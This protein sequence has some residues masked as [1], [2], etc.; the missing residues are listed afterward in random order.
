[1][2]QTFRPL[3]RHWIFRLGVPLALVAWAGYLAMDRLFDVAAI[4][5]MYAA[6]I[7]FANRP[8]IWQRDLRLDDQGL[9]ARLGRETVRVLWSDVIAAWQVKH[10]R[11]SFLNLSSEEVTVGIPLEF[12]GSRAIWEAVQRRVP[13][14][15][16]EAGAYRRSPEYKTHLARAQSLLKDVRE[17]LRADY[18]LSGKIALLAIGGF[19][20]ITVPL[21]SEGRLEN[22]AEV[23]F[24]LGPVLLI[25]V[26]LAALSFFYRV[27][28]TSE[29]VT[30]F[31][32]W[33]RQV[34]RWDEVEY[35]EHIY[36]WGRFV[37]VGRDRRLA[38]IGP[39]YL[40]GKDRVEMFEMLHAQIELRPIELRHRE[41]ALFTGSHNVAVGRS[42]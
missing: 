28:M 9:S 4:L 30:V 10:G 14:E 31:D 39:P 42:A 26:K 32:L 34:M 16:L 29:A 33:K 2:S 23:A 7:A 3:L 18:P 21:I 37:M 22:W 12:F 11:T 13:L 1:M 6:V 27:E 8:P 17:P 20:L 36:A 15:A 5:L 19:V 38:V 24:C 41:R 25:A 35:I 40:G